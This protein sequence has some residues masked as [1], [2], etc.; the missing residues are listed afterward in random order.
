M[1]KKC[2][3]LYKHCRNYNVNV[4]HVNGNI[5]GQLPLENMWR[6]FS[7]YK[8]WNYRGVSECCSGV[9]SYE[10]QCCRCLGLSLVPR[11]SISASDWSHGGHKPLPGLGWD[12]ETSP[13]YE[14][15]SDESAEWW[16]L[17]TR[18]IVRVSSIG[19]VMNM[20]VHGSGSKMRCLHPSLSF[21]SG[22]SDTKHK[23]L[24][25]SRSV[26]PG[27]GNIGGCH[28]GRDP[29]SGGSLGASLAVPATKVSRSTSPFSFYRSRSWDEKYLKTFLS[30]YIIILYK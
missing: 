18:N 27:A 13:G 25:N 15:S 3:T 21:S 28:Q 23:Q 24:Q 4:F 29:G 6:K 16:P 10:C 7:V 8:V 30:L 12:E 11:L 26:D 20:E 9:L 17:T 5:Y 22:S 1:R 14:G 19:C 2:A